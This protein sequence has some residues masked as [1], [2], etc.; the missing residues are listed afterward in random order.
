[1]PSNREASFSS[2]PRAASKLQSGRKMSTLSPAADTVCTA[3]QPQAV[4]KN[5]AGQQPNPPTKWRDEVWVSCAQQQ[6][7]V[8]WRGMLQERRKGAGRGRGG[9]GRGGVDRRRRTS[10][11][12][13]KE[14]KVKAV[15]S[16]KCLFFSSFSS[17][18]PLHLQAVTNIHAEQNSTLWS[19][20]TNLIPQERS[21]FASV[22]SFRI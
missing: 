14:D 6:T 7:R 1:M 8:G 15:A 16:Q 21:Q 3:G 2:Q 5:K 19:H 9:G 20:T 13:W 12:N 4:S 11:D 18:F 10:E 17:F 22:M